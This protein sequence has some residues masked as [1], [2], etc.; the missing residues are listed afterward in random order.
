MSIALFFITHEGIAS[1]LLAIGEAIVQKPNSNLSYAEV[2]M[3]SPTE[4]IVIDVE[5]KITS[6]ATTDGIFFITDVYGSTPSNIAQQLAVKYKTNLISGVNL[7]MIIR[8]LH[9]REEKTESLLEK[10]LDG[11][12]L[13]IQNHTEE[14]NI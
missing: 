10:A 14:T 2:P 4:Q 11:A 13:G 8:L 1:N 7:P 6:L 12:H 5:Q 3:D 9:Y